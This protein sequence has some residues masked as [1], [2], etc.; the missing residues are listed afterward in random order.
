MRYNY[1]LKPT[2][3]QIM[4]M[5]QIIGNQRFV[6]N[7][8]L[9]RE[10]VTYA[11][12]KKFKFYNSNAAD[13]VSL[14]KEYEWLKIG[15]SQALQQTL[16]DLNQALTQSFKRKNEVGFPKFKKKKEFDG[17]FRIV[18]TPN[19]WKWSKKAIT[20][21]KIGEIKWILHRKIP[22][23]FST[24]TIFKD[25]TKWYIS[26]VVDVEEQAPKQITHLH[27]VV[28]IDL[29]SENLIVT[30]DGEFYTNPKFFKKARKKLKKIQ[31][32]FAKTNAGSNRRKKKQLQVRKTYK[33]LTNQRKDY[34]HKISNQITNDY[35][36]LSTEDLNVKG[37]Q[38]F[39]GSMVQDAG[40]SMLV[41]MINYKAKLKGKTTVKIDRFAPS[42][43]ACNDCGTLHSMPL[44][45]RQYD[46][47]YCGMSQHRDVNAALN[48]RDWGLELHTGGTPGMGGACSTDGR[49]DTN[50]GVELSGS[51]RYVSLNRQKFLFRQLLDKK[52]SNL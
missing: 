36:L 21:P 44:H 27:Q 31:R 28:G 10:Q 38:R 45:L 41:G 19:L 9:N 4:L 18:Q 48:I 1:R 49:G 11:E 39:N 7:Y 32:Q 17:S 40:W 43:K 6:W 24:A 30:S 51:A 47:T 50:V 20:I 37:M 29:N 2:A 22:S 25:G 34:L 8:Y 16:M 3:E 12:S 13:L 52:A 26:L 5:N 35:D 23:D 46:C 42:S 15:P 33:K 14:K